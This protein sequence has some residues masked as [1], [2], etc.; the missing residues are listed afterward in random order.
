MADRPIT[1]AAEHIMTTQPEFCEEFA[2]YHFI[3]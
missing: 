3:E 1:L 2:V